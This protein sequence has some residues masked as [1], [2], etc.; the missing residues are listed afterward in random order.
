[1]ACTDT[2]FRCGPTRNIHMCVVSESWKF[3][4]HVSTDQKLTPN[5]QKMCL[6]SSPNPRVGASA[7]KHDEYVVTAT[8]CW[9]SL[10]LLLMLEYLC[11]DSAFWRVVMAPLVDSVGSMR[12]ALFSKG[13]TTF[14]LCWLRSMVSAMTFCPN[15]STIVTGEA[16]VEF[17]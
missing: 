9:G 3:C 13:S 17:E 5:I 12:V 4:S 2:D 10:Q 8:L 11:K 7:S 14:C 15:F 6:L 16:D 1:M